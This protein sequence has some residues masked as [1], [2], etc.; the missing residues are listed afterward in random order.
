MLW[1]VNCGGV[2]DLTEKWFI[3]ERKDTHIFLWDVH[4]PLH[5]ANIDHPQIGIIDDGVTDFSNYPTTE[6]IADM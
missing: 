5:H 4:K 3:H 1:F 2:I 6:E